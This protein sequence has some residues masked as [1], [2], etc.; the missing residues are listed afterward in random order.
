MLK[1]IVKLDFINLQRIVD[2]L[3]PNEKF[4]LIRKLE[5]DTLSNRIETLLKKI[6]KRRKEHPLATNEI[7]K[8]IMT[9][10]K[11]IYG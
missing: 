7:K 5:K 8:E 6:D 3:S 10:R 4:I 11:K 2:Q 9:V 1:A